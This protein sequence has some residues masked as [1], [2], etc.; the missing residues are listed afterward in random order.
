[1]LLRAC[2]FLDYDVVKFNSRTP[3]KQHCVDGESVGV[4]WQLIVSGKGTCAVSASVL[5]LLA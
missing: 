3:T 2:V 1:M 5:F 4:R